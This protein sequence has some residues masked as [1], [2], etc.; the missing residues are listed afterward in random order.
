MCQKYILF[1]FILILNNILKQT[2]DNQ[3]KAN[4]IGLALIILINS[5]S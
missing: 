3:K 4:P 5:I 2:I 1:L